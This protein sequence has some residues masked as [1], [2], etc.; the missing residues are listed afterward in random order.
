ML[1]W[2]HASRDL[3]GV[4]MRPLVL[5]GRCFDS[6]PSDLPTP[7]LLHPEQCR[8]AVWTCPP[9]TPDVLLSLA[10]LGFCFLL[11]LLRP[12]C[13]HPCTAA[14]GGELS[15]STTGP[16]PPRNRRMSASGF[17]LPA[18]PSTLAAT[19]LDS[20]AHAA[21]RP[22]S[23]MATPAERQVEWYGASLHSLALEEDAL[24]RVDPLGGRRGSPR[25]VGM[26]PSEDG[27]EP[28]G[29][30]LLAEIA[31]SCRGAVSNADT[32]PLPWPLLID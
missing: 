6:L 11:L 18:S 1:A 24:R 3:D 28:S 22:F 5:R 4:P 30:M 25:G 29:R 16:P 14:V 7:T 21:G 27:A 32:Q 13:P 23:A 26:A 2:F 10:S 15:L 31:L 9:Y 20:P 12:S 19:A 8:H 17:L